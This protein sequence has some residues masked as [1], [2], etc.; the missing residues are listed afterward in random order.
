VIVYYAVLQLPD[1]QVVQDSSPHESM[2]A[3]TLH[4]LR[5]ENYGVIL[6]KIVAERI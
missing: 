5:L 2:T 6:L 1:G 4:G 3:A